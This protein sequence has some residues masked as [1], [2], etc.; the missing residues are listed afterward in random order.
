MERF[1]GLQ[2]GDVIS[3]VEDLFDSHSFYSDS[4]W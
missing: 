1:E 4:Y 3:G 2:A